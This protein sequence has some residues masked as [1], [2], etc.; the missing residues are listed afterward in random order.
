MCVYVRVCMAAG[1]AYAT[2]CYYD[3]QLMTCQPTPEEEIAL[4]FVNVTSDPLNRFLQGIA[5]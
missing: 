2:G 3:P 4:M 1:V 5:T